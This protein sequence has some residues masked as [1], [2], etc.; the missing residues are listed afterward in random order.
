MKLNKQSQ[1]YRMALMHQIDSLSTVMPSFWYGLTSW[2]Y[3]TNPTLV[4]NYHSPLY[5]FILSQGFFGL[6]HLSDERKTKFAI[7]LKQIDLYWPAFS[8]KFKRL[9]PFDRTACKLCHSSVLN[10]ITFQKGQKE[11]T[12]SSWSTSKWILIFEG[13]PINFFF[14]NGTEIQFSTVHVF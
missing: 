11:E 5:L 9:A 13:L 14:C 10:S 2:A 4:T 1:W 6:S 12:R 8:I 7:F 3:L